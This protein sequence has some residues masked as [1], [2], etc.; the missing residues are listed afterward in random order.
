VRPCVQSF[1]H[2]LQEASLA[3][4]PEVAVGGDRGRDSMEEEELAWDSARSVVAG[5]HIR[6]A[7]S[8]GR[9]LGGGGPEK[10]IGVKEEPHEERQSGVTTA[11]GAN[12]SKWS[13]LRR[14]DY[15]LIRHILFHSFTLHLYN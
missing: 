10:E 4:R 11:G 7:F 2:A 15:D 14:R 9:D 13:S 8:E 5:R 3:D 12:A 1:F 6:E